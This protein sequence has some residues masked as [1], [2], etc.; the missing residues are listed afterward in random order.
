MGK[1]IHLSVQGQFMRIVFGKFNYWKNFCVYN[2]NVLIFMWTYSWGGL[3]WKV[4]GINQNI[5]LL[6]E[7]TAGGT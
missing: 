7:R 4:Y 1:I 6:P 5:L 3:F 2:V